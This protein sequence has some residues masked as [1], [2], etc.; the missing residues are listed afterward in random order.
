MSK[1]G[2]EIVMALA[3]AAVCTITVIA[4]KADKAEQR[5]DTRPEK[6]IELAPSAAPHPP[7]GPP[8]IHEHCAERPKY[9]D[10]VVLRTGY[11][12]AP[13]CAKW[14]ILYEHH[15]ECDTWAS[16]EKK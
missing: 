4:W 14:E 12:E 10:C 9:L 3:A 16:E 11:K 2:T 15:C 7:A 1:Y 5:S 13:S 8:C 6:T